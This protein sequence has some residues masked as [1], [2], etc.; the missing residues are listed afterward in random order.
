LAQM[1]GEELPEYRS[2]EYTYKV[3]EGWLSWSGP[4]KTPTSG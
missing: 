2:F 4:T 1:L 3:V